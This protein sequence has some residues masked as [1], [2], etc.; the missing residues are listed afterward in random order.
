MAYDNV[1]SALGKIYKFHRDNFA[2]AQL[3]VVVEKKTWWNNGIVLP[4]EHGRARLLL[5]DLVCVQHSDSACR[6]LVG[7]IVWC[8]KF[9]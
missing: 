6:Y 1:V 7:G 9:Y 5:M 8:S 4:L 3:E 2:S